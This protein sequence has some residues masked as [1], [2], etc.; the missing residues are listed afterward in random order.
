MGRKIL[1]KFQ[2][3]SNCLGVSKIFKEIISVTQGVCNNAVCRT[4]LATLGL[5]IRDRD[6]LKLPKNI[7]IFHKNIFIF[8]ILN[9]SFKLMF[10]LAV[11]LIASKVRTSKTLRRGI[12]RV[13]SISATVIHRSIKVKPAIYSANELSWKS[14]LLGRSI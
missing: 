7:L 11:V 12:M 1:W 3:C 4:G 13:P 8:L 5:L 9:I 14:L 10:C 6:N 2:L